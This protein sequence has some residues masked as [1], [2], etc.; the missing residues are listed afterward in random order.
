MNA[1]LLFIISLFD[2]NN[3]SNIELVG[4]TPPTHADEHD[5]DK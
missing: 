1:L 3:E 2:F 5:G 4:G